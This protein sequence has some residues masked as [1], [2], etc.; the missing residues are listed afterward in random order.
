LSS[1]RRVFVI[2]NI[3]LSVGDDSGGGEGVGALLYGDRQRRFEIDDRT[4][5]HLQ[6]VI[7]AK[8]RRRESFFFSVRDEDGSAGRVSVWMSPMVPLH[9]KYYGSRA[10]MINRRWVEALHEVANSP[11]GLILLEEPAE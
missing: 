5:A 7:S 4:L 1:P 11:A 6:L 3:V 2:P 10:P 8:L 9:F